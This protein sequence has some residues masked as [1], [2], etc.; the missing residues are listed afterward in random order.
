MKV[1]ATNG[2]GRGGK[3][4]TIPSG[5]FN[6]EDQLRH[7]SKDGVKKGMK[8]KIEFF[9]SR[10]LKRERKNKSARGSNA[11]KF[12]KKRQKQW[13]SHCIISRGNS[14]RLST[15]NQQRGIEKVKRR[16]NDPLSKLKT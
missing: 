1:N 13:T 4:K 2:R 14:K 12:E 16:E 15:R 11:R 10:A 8:K 5:K 9:K 6:G 3:R 7:M